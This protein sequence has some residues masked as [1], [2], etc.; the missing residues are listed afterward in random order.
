MPVRGGITHTGS[1]LK[2]RDIDAFTAADIEI[3]NYEH[4]PHIAAPIS[5]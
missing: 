1:L 5:V 2:G 3:L 4:H